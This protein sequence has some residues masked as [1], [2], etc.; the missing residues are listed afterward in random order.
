MR[1]TDFARGL[2]TEF[3]GEN[4]LGNQDKGGVDNSS[5]SRGNFWRLSIQ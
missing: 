1:K 2:R 4:K 5:L 3:V